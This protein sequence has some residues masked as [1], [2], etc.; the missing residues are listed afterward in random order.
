MRGSEVCRQCKEPP[1]G[2]VVVGGREGGI[3]GVV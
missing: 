3:I 2:E 1:V